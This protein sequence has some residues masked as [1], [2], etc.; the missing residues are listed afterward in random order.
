MKS[1][2]IIE[3]NEEKIKIIWVNSSEERRRNA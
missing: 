3:I 2:R 1:D